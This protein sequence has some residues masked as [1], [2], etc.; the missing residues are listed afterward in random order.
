MARRRSRKKLPIE[1]ITVNIE[2]L[3]AD[4]KGVAIHDEKNG[5]CVG[6]FAW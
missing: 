5:T 4:A 2:R 6:G 3:S 1:P